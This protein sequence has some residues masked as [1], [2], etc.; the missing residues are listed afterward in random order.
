MGLTNRHQRFVDEYIIDLNAT[1]AAIRAGYAPKA[2]NKQAHLLMLRPD[3]QAAIAEAQAS[4]SERTK[5]DADWVLRRLVDEAEADMAD[6]LDESGALKPVREWPLIWRKGLVAGLD[7][8]EI[9]QD[10]A[11][12]G[13][14]RKVKMSERH[15]RTELIGKHVRVQAFN[16]KVEFTGAGGGPVQI[17][18]IR[19]VI[20]DPRNRD[21]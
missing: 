9:R 10:G 14:I 6:L 15:K 13:V 5:I 2:A 18:T 7:V 11:V 20:V 1:Q 21:A 16:E 3:V 19:R 8:E 17:E 4:R 12:V